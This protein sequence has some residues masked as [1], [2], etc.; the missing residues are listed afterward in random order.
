[1]TGLVVRPVGLHAA[2]VSVDSAAA[3]LALS[4]WLRER[5]Q[6]L[7]IVPAAA[8]VLVDGCEP[9]DVAAIV[10]H[11]D[12]AVDVVEGP[13]VEIPVVYDGPDLSSVADAVGL[14]V[15]DV[16]TAHAGVEHVV[17]FGGFSPGFGYLAGSPWDVPRLASPRSRVP[18]GSVAL[19][20][21]WTGIYPSASPGGWQLIGRTD[22]VLWDPARESPALLA[23]GTR[24][25]FVP[26]GSGGSGD[27]R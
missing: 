17:A 22:A 23:P 15:A 24:V 3:A 20:G 5:V 27:R 12:G 7:D 4:L 6:A 26:G 11:W 18:S 13:L 2:L 1:V 19:A 10:H 8:T 21:T 14:S 16:V 9:A 25:R